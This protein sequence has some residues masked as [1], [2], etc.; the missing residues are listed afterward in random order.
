MKYSWIGYI[1]IFT[2]VCAVLI[3]FPKWIV[4]DAYITFRYAYNLVEYG[5][6]TFNPGHDPIEGYTGVMLPLIIA[7]SFKLGIPP[8]IAAQ[9]LGVGS[10]LLVLFLFDRL[11][12][13]LGAKIALRLPFLWILGTAAFLYVHVFS[14][15]ETMLFT[16]LL[17]GVALQ[18]YRLLDTRTPSFVQHSSTALSLL[19]LSLCRPEG[20]VY[21][22]IVIC[23]LVG[24]SILRWKSFRPVAAILLFFILPGTLYF[25]WRWTYYGYMLPNTFYAKLSEHIS[26]GT[27]YSALAFFKRYLLL[28]T[29]GVAVA[30]IS[31]F[32]EIIYTIRT[33]RLKFTAIANLLI[34]GSFL[35]FSLFVIGHYSRTNLT[36]NFSYRFFTPFY[37][38]ALLV[39][40][41][42]LSI[43]IDT[44]KSNMRKR[45]Y[46]YKLISITFFLLFLI[47]STYNFISLHMKEIP[48][49]SDYKKLLSEMHHEAGLFLR[50]RVPQSEWLIV[51]IDAGAIPY[52]SRLNTIDFGGLNDEYIAH[53]KKLSISNRV[54]Y[55]FSKKPGA[56][57]FTTYDWDFVNHGKE[58]DAIV[59]DHR[60]KNYALV[61]KFGNSTGKNY[62]EFVF[63]RR[64][65]LRHNEEIQFVQK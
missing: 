32:D 25:L 52:Y 21:S 17:L 33:K 28:P 57:V 42:L 38:T 16:A 36:M 44:I 29:L 40:V 59:A 50:V 47:Q 39:L 37:P 46:K 58:A 8:K 1:F 7:L 60:F 43:A 55:F 4:D 5:Q 41:W 48:F 2:V 45:P 64:D 65:L 9:I 31:F 18:L 54:N 10:F 22:F 11:A 19:I 63:L 26:G 13:M 56:L 24:N 3:V 62:F 12:S 51:H 23:I 14:G 34:I 15:L 61:K 53:N 30:W 20:A 35:T 6:L 49:T 27:L